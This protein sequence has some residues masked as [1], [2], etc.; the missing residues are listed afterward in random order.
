VVG[1][2]K[3]NNSSGFLLN[4]ICFN[5]IR[6]LL[7]LHKQEGCRVESSEEFKRDL[8]QNKSEV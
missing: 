3:R 4:V 2:S 1:L 5:V 7:D 8:E 6:G